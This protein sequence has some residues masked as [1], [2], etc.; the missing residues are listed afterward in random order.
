MVVISADEKKVSLMAKVDADALL[1][2]V[3]IFRVE[4]NQTIDRSRRAK[5]G[6]FFT[7]PT[8]ARLMASMFNEGPNNI[9]IL[10]A[11]AGVGSLSAALIAEIC[12]WNLNRNQ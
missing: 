7:P 12:S 4:A 2:Q 8:A 9:A 3:D 11:G 10:D 5:L 1:G 6:Q